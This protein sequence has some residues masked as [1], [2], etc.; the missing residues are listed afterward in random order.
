[1]ATLL[2]PWKFLFNNGKK[3]MKR[4]KNFCTIK[5]LVTRAKVVE[6]VAELCHAIENKLLVR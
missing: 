3:K 2:K 5:L 6:K 4:K 1:V